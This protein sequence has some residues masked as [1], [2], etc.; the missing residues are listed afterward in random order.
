MIKLKSKINKTEELKKA[1]AFASRM[2]RLA[3]EPEVS[4]ERFMEGV[5]YTIEQLKETK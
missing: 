5:K 3:Y 4:F 1:K 2:Y